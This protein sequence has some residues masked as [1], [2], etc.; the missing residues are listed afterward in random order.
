MSC[1]DI[2]RLTCLLSLFPFC[3]CD[4]HTVEVVK[5]PLLRDGPKSRLNG[6]NCKS[7]RVSFNND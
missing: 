1:E 6:M 3:D 4:D 2:T 7:F 5:Q